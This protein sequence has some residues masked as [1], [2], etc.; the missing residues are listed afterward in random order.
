MLTGRHP[1][2]GAEVSNLS[3]ALAEE[4]SVD[5]MQRGVIVARLQRGSQAHRLGVQPRDIIMSI[6]DHKIHRIKDL[7]RALARAADRWKITLK[8]GGRTLTTLVEG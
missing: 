5:P 3:P 1:F 2:S 8:R 6:N 7:E 4:L